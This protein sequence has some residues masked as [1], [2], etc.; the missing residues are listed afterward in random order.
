MSYLEWVWQAILWLL[1]TGGLV[2][3][4]GAVVFLVIA[5]GYSVIK[6]LRVGIN[7]VE[8]DPKYKK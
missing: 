6:A 5:L 3:V 8:N 2:L 7:R 4:A 1:A